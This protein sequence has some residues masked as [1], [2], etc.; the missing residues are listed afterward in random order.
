MRL[1]FFEVRARDYLRVHVPSLIVD[2]TIMLVTGE[3]TSKNTNLHSFES[4][5][6]CSKSENNLY[7]DT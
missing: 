7:T 6:M 3:K 4:M 2:M 5:S 1:A